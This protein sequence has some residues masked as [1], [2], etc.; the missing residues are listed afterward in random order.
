MTLET[1]R[2]CLGLDAAR[3]VLWLVL[4]LLAAVAAGC[5]VRPLLQTREA[6]PFRLSQSALDGDPAR[7][8]SV[9]LVLEGLLA[10]RDG[11]ASL[12]LGRYQSAIQV[13]PGNPYAYLALARFHLDGGDP[14]RAIAFLDQAEALLVAEDAVTPGLRVHL[15]GLRGAA[16]RR[17]GRSADGDAFLDEARTRAPAVWGDGRLSPE[18]LL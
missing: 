17:L 11:D 12:G 2:P 18:E 9:G 15:I 6:E 8:A 10:E 7:R 14:A 4:V 3:P 13:D 1:S 5:A 16:L